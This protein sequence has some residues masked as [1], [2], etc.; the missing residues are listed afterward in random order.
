MYAVKSGVG[1]GP[2]PTAIADAEA[3]LL[4]VLGPI[5]ELARSWRLLTHPDLR[6]TPRIAT[7][8]D[9]VIEQRDDLKS[10]LTG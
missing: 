5:P 9:F 6:R 7:F 8:F 3:D 1:I 10:I 2:L 4:R